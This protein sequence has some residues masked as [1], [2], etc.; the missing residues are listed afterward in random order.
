MGTAV[1]GDDEAGAVGELFD[2][3]A[4]DGTADE[5]AARHRRTAGRV[6]DRTD[7]GPGDRL[8]DLG[9]GNGWACRHAASRFGAEA[10]GV[11][12]ALRM[13]ALA[14]QHGAGPVDGTGQAGAA[15]VPAPS[16][17][18]ADFA[19]LPFAD[20]SFD[21]C[22]SMEALYYAADLDAVLAD[23]RRVLRPGTGLHAVVDYYEENEASHGWPE[24]CGVPM[25][26]LSE[27]GWADAF[28]AAGFE[29][30]ATE[31]VRMEPEEGELTM[32]ADAWMVEE[33]SLHVAGVR[34]Q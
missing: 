20:A 10:V 25:L 5:A 6:L 28:E 2:R 27:R 29:A 14:R 12:L 18:R 30:V 24:D 13:L 3:W 11:D 17:V 22:F 16:Y 1:E 26:L 33:G 23:V 19:G 34:P 31:R 15:E 7:L 9:T 32:A 8:L 4:T 21:A